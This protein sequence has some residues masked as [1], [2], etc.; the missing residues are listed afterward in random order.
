MAGRLNTGV[1]LLELLIAMVLFATISLG[2]FAL[3]TF[4]RRQVLYSERQA[5]VQNEVS[6]ALEHITREVTRAVGSTAIT[7]Q[8]PVDLTAISGD[9]ALR[10]YVDLAA[11]GI[12]AGDGRWGTPGDRWR[13][14]RFTGASGAVSGRYQLWYYPNYVNN[15]STSEVIARNI[16]GFNVSTT[17]NY[18][19]VSIDGCWDP[20][21]AIGAC[22]SAQ[23]P[24][25]SMVVSIYMPSVSTN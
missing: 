25:V 1:S 15:S 11:D 23:N 10:V 13:A 20:A 6:I 8:S 19:T 21:G 16:D 12:S 17:S 14:Y 5:K 3:D 4:S 7:G 9:A 24:R 2:F 18:V 22:G